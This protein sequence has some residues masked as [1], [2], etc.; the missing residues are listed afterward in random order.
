MLLTMASAVLRLK[1]PPRSGNRGQCELGVCAHTRSRW[2]DDD[3]I[4]VIRNVA[5]KH[6]KSVTFMPKPIFGDNGSGMHVHQSIW[7]EGQPCS[8]DGYVA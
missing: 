5:K 7:K 2:F 1:T 6:G 4:C 8:G 3:L